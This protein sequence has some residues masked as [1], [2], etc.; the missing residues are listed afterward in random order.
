[1]KILIMPDSFKGSLSAIDVA[2]SIENGIK[3]V[4]ADTETVVIPMADGGEGTLQALVNATNGEI[5]KA[6][7]LD[8]LGREIN[9]YYGI[10]GDGSTA[11]I[12]IAIASGLPLLKEE[13][14]DAL[15]ASTFGTGQL[16]MHAL[17]NGAT[18]FIICLGGSAT[19]DGGT[20]IL[21]AL[22]YKFLDHEG[23]ELNEG[24]LSLRD[25]AFIDE[26]DVSPLVKQAKFRIA[27]DV[28]NPFVG[29]NGASYIFGP[30]KGATPDQIVQLDQSLQV[31]AD[32]IYKQKGKRIHN[33]K[34]AG[35]AG[36]TAGGLISLLNAELQQGV[37]LVMEALK[38][39]ELVEN[40]KFDFVLTGEGKLDYQT[41]YG[42]V[43]AGVTKLCNPSDIP[44][45]AL[46]GQID[47]E[48]SMINEVGLTAAFS[49]TNGPMS[50]GEAM[51]NTKKLLE[52]SGEQ[53]FRLFL[54]GSLNNKNIHSKH[55]T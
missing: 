55:I 44:V 36:G 37:E 32:V 24:G 34:G 12:E 6:A 35:A 21:K 48:G 39:Q 10:M 52:L 19:N 41:G 33:L 26:S 4:N 29:S 13:E 9:G 30:Q 43:I 45:I 47:A 38:L 25:L 46:C 49:I 14:M 7:V 17:K 2:R 53:I 42:K 23:K 40:G 15:N 11:V 5:V 18:S 27:C 51:F 22:G 20:G 54:A 1:M 31:F 8:P 3:K 16:I 50:L 28:N